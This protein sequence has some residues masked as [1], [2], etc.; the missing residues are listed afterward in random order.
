MQV[1]SVKL[2]QIWS[3]VLRA[4]GARWAKFIH[5]FVHHGGTKS[6]VPFMNGPMPML[7]PDLHLLSWAGIVP[8]LVIHVALLRTAA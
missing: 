3:L 7:N 5:A 8:H 1:K 2:A 4:A 6:N